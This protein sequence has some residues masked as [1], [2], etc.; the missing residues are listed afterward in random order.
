MKSH[1]CL[2]F[3]TEYTPVSLE[4]KEYQKPASTELIIYI[5][6]LN[7]N[8]SHAFENEHDYM[9]RIDAFEHLQMP[10]SNQIDSISNMKYIYLIMLIS[11]S[12]L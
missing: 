7:T 4:E 5:S 12:I 10:S 2:I 3:K 6:M 9:L 1:T 11:L 8:S